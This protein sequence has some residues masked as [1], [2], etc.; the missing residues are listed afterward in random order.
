MHGNDGEEPDTISALIISDPASSA[1]R[2]HQP[3]LMAHMG[4][5]FRLLE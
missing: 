1:K 3:E 2:I 4:A 5:V